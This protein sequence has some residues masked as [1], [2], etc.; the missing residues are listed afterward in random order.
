MNTFLNSSHRDTH[1]YSI[2][3]WIINYILFISPKNRY[4]CKI[5]YGKMFD[6]T[7]KVTKQHINILIRYEKNRYKTETFVLLKISISFLFYVQSIISKICNIFKKY[8]KYIFTININLLQNPIRTKCVYW[9][10]G[11]HSFFRFKNFYF[12]P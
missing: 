5:L 9:W 3:Y 2:K 6:W 12:N 7:T 8:W 11:S 4:F 1:I 10:N